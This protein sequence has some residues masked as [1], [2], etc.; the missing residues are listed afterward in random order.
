MQLPVTERKYCDFILYA[1]NGPISV[2]R[3]EQD[4]TGKGRMTSKVLRMNKTA[5]PKHVHILN[6]NL[7]AKNSSL[8]TEN[9]F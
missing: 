8:R 7:F 5:L 4:D 2:E 6:A 1:E 9:L 3:I